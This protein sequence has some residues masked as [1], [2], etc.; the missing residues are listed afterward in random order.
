ELLVPIVANLRSGEGINGRAALSLFMIAAVHVALMAMVL[1]VAGSM[2]AGWQVFGLAGKGEAGRDGVAAQAAAAAVP[3]PAPGATPGSAPAA[4]ARRSAGLV[5]VAI[6]AGGES[7]T[8]TAR[9]AEGTTRSSSRTVI[10][11]TGSEN[12]ALP[13]RQPPRTRG[14]G[15]RFS[16]TA[17]SR[18]EMIR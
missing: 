15:S 6:M 14:V 3:F 9:T 17:G 2:V 10:T 8:S 11:Q 12:S 13:P 5:P 7:S 4:F 18:R 1:R 16:S